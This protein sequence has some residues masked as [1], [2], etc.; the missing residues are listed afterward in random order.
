MILEDIRKNIDSI[1]TELVHL[2]EKRMDLV[3]QVA[4]YK[5]ESGKAILDTSREQAVLERIESLVK[6]PE[7]RTTI[8]D[9]FADIMAQSRTYQKEKLNVK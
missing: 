4:A 1:D 2:L 3:N 5:K 7:Y 9:S 6:N 8:R